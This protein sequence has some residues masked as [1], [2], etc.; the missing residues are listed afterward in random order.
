MAKQLE[1]LLNQCPTIGTSLFSHTVAIQFFTWSEHKFFF[2]LKIFLFAPGSLNSGGCSPRINTQGQVSNPIEIIS[3][4][5][6]M[7]FSQIFFF[8]FGHLQRQ[9]NNVPYSRPHIIHKSGLLLSKR[10]NSEGVMYVRM[11]HLNCI[12]LNLALHV[13]TNSLPVI[14]RDFYI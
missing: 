10:C 12:S 11:I 8:I 4:I 3:D 5:V 6:C 2:F 9:W 7:T 1:T 13:L 14:F